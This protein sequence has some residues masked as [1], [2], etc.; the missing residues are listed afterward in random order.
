MLSPVTSASQ[1]ESSPIH[2][3]LAAVMAVFF[4]LACAGLVPVAW[5]AKR[6]Y[7][8]ARVYVES[9][10]EIIEY[11]PIRSGWNTRS[12]QRPDR[13]VRPSFVFRFATKTGETITT[14]GF[15]AYGGREAPRTEYADLRAGGRAP[16][17]YDPS[18]PQQAVLSRRFNPHFYWVITLPLGLMCFTGL[19][20]RECLRRA[21]PE[22]RLKG[23][24][25]GQRLSWRLPAA[26]SQQA[27]TGCLGFMMLISALV[28]A[29]MWMAA[30]DYQVPVY[31]YRW[32]SS[33]LGFNLNG[34]WFV[35]LAMAALT[36]VFVWAFLVNL[37]WIVVPEPVVE[38]NDTHLRPGQSTRLHLSQRGPLK[39]ESLNAYLVCEVNGAKGKEALVK[40]VVISAHDLNLPGRG[41]TAPAEFSGELTIPASA[42]L[43][44]KSVSA[45]ASSTVGQGGTRVQQSGKQL[46]A[47]L[48]RVERRVSPK[49]ALQTDFEIVVSRESA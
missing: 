11:I 45:T 19:V 12:G 39:A 24:V 9:E 15:D 14:R 5:Q 41:E 1:R 47:W 31:R 34:W 33:H 27:M 22:P 42:R 44:C 30:M 8:V 40:E 21:D 29:G 2:G 46:V 25:K 4:L 20:F 37:R 23:I 16:A 43:T 6:D 49:M 32:L 3:K 13:T 7:R 36:A 38:I 10:A 26:V 17:W 18:D 35:M 48:I 28:T